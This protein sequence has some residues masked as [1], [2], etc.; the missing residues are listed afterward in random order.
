MFQ[1]TKLSHKGQITVPAEVRKRLQLKAGD[2]LA[3]EVLE[4]GKMSVH[5]VEEPLDT[6]YLTALND[7]LLE[8]NSA[9]DD[10]AYRNL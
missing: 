8:W 10:E 3:W 6:S 7:V 5:R 2:T 4:N 9:E 1:L